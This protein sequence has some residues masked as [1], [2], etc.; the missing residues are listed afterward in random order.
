MLSARQFIASRL[1][2]E[3]SGRRAML[4]KSAQAYGCAPRL[5]RAVAASR[6]LIAQR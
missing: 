2:E 5:A 1:F 3:Y 4:P 6:R